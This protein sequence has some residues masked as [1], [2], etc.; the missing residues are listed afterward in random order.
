[1]RH[2]LISVRETVLL[3][4]QE[5]VPYVRGDIFQLVDPVGRKA[6]TYLTDDMRAELIA[7]SVTHDI[8]MH[9][10]LYRL[11]YT[12]VY[13]HPRDRLFQLL[14]PNYLPPR[15]LTYCTEEEAEQI[16]R[17]TSER[18][19]VIHFSEDLHLDIMEALF[20]R[21]FF[22]MYEKISE[23]IGTKT[24]NLYNMDFKLGHISLTNTLE[25]FR[26]VEFMRMHGHEYK[27]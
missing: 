17:T 2:Y 12:K 13:T 21:H 3:F 27:K 25:D 18:F 5:V 15:H 9:S 24:W 19:R 22:H 11:K 16:Y 23:F 26:I 10:L 4:K 7:M 1:M 6:P 14:D 8:A 20:D